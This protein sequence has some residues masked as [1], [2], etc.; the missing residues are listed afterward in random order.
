[1]ISKEAVF[2][3]DYSTQIEVAGRTALGLKIIQ[4]RIRGPKLM[5]CEVRPGMISV[6][7]DASSPP[8]SSLVALAR[9]LLRES[10]T[11]ALR[12]RPAE[13]TGLLCFIPD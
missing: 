13:L 9:A 7:G 3:P 10:G 8:A 11:S 4:R 5:M 12:E 2:C 1:M 6:P